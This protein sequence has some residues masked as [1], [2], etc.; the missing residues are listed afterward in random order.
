MKNQAIVHGMEAVGVLMPDGDRF[1]FIAVKFSVWA[2]DG[3]LY[4]TPAEAQAAVQAHFAGARKKE[5]AARDSEPHSF[6]TAEGYHA[7]A[8]MRAAF[9]E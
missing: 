6:P 5:A 8:D 7:F 4:D 3:S 1:R 9:S 2:L